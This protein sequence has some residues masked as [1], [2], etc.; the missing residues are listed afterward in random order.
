MPP[1]CSAQVIIRAVG[2]CDGTAPL[3]TF[4]QPC[5]GSALDAHRAIFKYV[6]QDITGYHDVREFRTAEGLLLDGQALVHGSAFYPRE[7]WA[8]RGEE[9]FVFPACHVGSSFLVPLPSVGPDAFVNV[10]VS[11]TTPRVM[12]VDNFLSAEECNELI[13]AAKG[14][15]AP[16]TVSSQGESGK[17]FREQSRTSS[18]AWMP[19]HSHSLAKKLYDRVSDLVGIPFGKHKHV[20]VEDLQVLRYEV[21]QHY[22]THH[23][24]F[25]PKMHHG[26]LQGDG[27][28][29]FITVLF[30]LSDV[31]EGGETCFPMAGDPRPLHSYSDCGRGLRVP[32]TAGKAVVFY[33]LMAKGQRI[34]G[35]LDESSWHSGC[36]VKKG[37]K[38]GANYWVTLKHVHE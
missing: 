13:Q 8:L 14:K 7:V 1:E 32:P 29:R 5:D 30:Y 28:N 35:Q 20:V 31:D 12:T 19:P 16:S 37:T 9:L 27:R 38:W 21:D 34:P 3:G 10:T 22:H 15:M 11:S 17:S 26:F 23:D 2:D 24:Y 36:D 6:A 33:S 4:A 18:T 25:D